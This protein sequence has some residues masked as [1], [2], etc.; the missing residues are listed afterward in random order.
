MDSDTEQEGY[1]VTIFALTARETEM[2]GRMASSVW[3]PTH[4]LAV[5]RTLEVGADKLFKESHARA[6]RECASDAHTCLFWLLEPYE[7]YDNEGSNPSGPISSFSGRAETDR[8][9]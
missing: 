1:H 8:T 6:A 3:E 5:N 7:P 9:S 4:S 2:P